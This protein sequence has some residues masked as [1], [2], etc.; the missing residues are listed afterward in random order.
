MPLHLLANFEIQKCYQ[1]ESNFN[2][3][4]SINNL[5]KIK[6]GAYVINLDENESVGTHWIALYVNGNNGI[7]IVLELNVFQKKLKNSCAAKI[8]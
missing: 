3:V 2:G 1:N 5:P 7:L 6:D 8:L 4:Y